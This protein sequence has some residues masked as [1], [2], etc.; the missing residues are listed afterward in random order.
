LALELLF[1]LE[2]LF[3]PWGSVR[4]EVDMSSPLGPIEI[5][6]DAPPYPVVQVC[7][8]IRFQ[9]PEEVRWLRMSAF[10]NWQDGRHQG[11]SLQSWKMLWK[12][13]KRAGRTCTCGGP[14]PELRLIAFTFNMGDKASYFFGQCHRSR[15]IF[16]DEP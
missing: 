9:S 14:L 7:R 16:R 1:G 6:C 4:P 15:T 12:M 13:G 10:R 3:D 11:P 8:H 5:C 2:Q